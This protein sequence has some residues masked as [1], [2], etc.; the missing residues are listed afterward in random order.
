MGTRM[1]W[2]L[3]ISGHYKIPR[4]VQTLIRITSISRMNIKLPLAAF[5]AMLFASCTQLPP[6]NF[7]PQNV[8][9]VSRR[10]DADLKSITVSVAQPGEKKGAIDFNME[11][12]KTIPD[13]WKSG[14]EDAVNRSLAFSDSSPRKVNLRVTILRFATPKFGSEM[15][16]KTT[17]RYEIQDRE[18]GAILFDEEIAAEGDVPLDYAFVGVVRAMESMNRSV[19]NNIQEFLKVLNDK[20]LHGSSGRMSH[21]G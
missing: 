7:T 2:L 19:Q 18:S 20:G 17:A 8:A 14:L 4:P 11:Y 9:R 1:F 10:A 15:H 12:S 13:I 3:D 21:R 6:L 5:S 16:T